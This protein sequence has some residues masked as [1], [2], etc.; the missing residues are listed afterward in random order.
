MRVYKLLETNEEIQLE[1]AFVLENE[2]SSVLDE[3]TRNSTESNN[4]SRYYLLGKLSN[5][6]E[7]DIIEAA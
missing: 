2:Y 3:L 5:D 7:E 4:Q 1:T 6:L